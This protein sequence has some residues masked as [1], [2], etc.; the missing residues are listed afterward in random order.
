VE[1]SHLGVRRLLR[2]LRFP[3]L[4]ERDHYALA[5]RDAFG[6]SSAREALTEL[7]EAVL[8]RYPPVYRTIIKR[9]DVDGEPA[10]S[11]AGELYLSYR[12]LH[13]Y[14]TTAIAAIAEA[15][16]RRFGVTGAAGSLQSEAGVTA[17][18]AE[19]FRYLRRHSLRS[20]EAAGRCFT[21]A[22][23]ID[24]SN[25]DAWVGLATCHEQQAISLERDAAA[26]FDAAVHA[27]DRA[28]KLAPERPDVFEALHRFAGRD[29]SS[30]GRWTGAEDRVCTARLLRDG[31]SAPARIAAASVT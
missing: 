29:R 3:D 1:H 27:L 8:H 24:D 14:R 31:H 19:G 23:E 11:V 7:L 2:K 9:I 20:I 17:L 6:G 12:T 13:R 30:S 25:A 16:E 15:L 5:V 22:L 10:R 4:L 21:R 28:A 18:V 26:S